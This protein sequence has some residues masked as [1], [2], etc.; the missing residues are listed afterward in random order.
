MNKQTLFWGGLLL[1]LVGVAAGIF[2][3]IPG[4]PHLIAD[5]RM[6]VKHAIAFFAL[7]VVGILAAVV[8]RPQSHA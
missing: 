6:H 7:G 8:N 1:F 5:T 2:F 3:L 4:I